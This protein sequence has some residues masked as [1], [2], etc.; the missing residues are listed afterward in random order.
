MEPDRFFLDENELEKNCTRSGQNGLR[1]EAVCH[2]EQEINGTRCM[3][4]HSLPVKMSLYPT[5]VLPEET[6]TAKVLL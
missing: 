2:L 6:G 4:M 3:F 5:T 1:W